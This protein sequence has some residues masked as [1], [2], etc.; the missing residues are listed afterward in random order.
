MNVAL[1]WKIPLIKTHVTKEDISAI[2]RVLERGMFLACGPEIE[3]F[4]R[5]IEEYLGN[6]VKV[7]TFNSGTS[8]LQILLEAHEIKGFKVIVP[9][10]TFIATANAVLLAGGTPIFAESE[11]ETFG[12]SYDSVKNLIDEKGVKAVMIMHYGGC[13]ARDTY[14]IK[15][16]CEDKKIL[17]LEDAAQSFSSNINGI[18]TGTFGESS[19]FSL[20]QNKILT[21]GEGGLLVTKNMKIYEKAKLLRSHGRV[22]E[23]VDYFNNT[24]D[25]DYIVPGYNA[26]MPTIN[27]AF[28]L[29]QLRNVPYVQRARNFLASRLSEG[30]KSLPIRL[31]IQPK[32]HLHV[33]QMYT[34]ILNDKKTRDDLQEHLTRKRIMTKVYFQPIH[35]KTLYKNHA[36]LPQTE[37]LA[38]KV[39]T[40]PLYPDLTKEEVDYMIGCIREYFER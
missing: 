31:P 1:D 26:R 30:L 20:C 22:E 17:F 24:K 6:G 16:L 13:P 34:M 15:K 35:L 36:Q 5:A 23:A 25:N 2:N 37:A 21:T 9:S 4:E 18:M 33:F 14:K 19:I 3:E 38:E 10:F 39:L 28:G 40:L 7:L 8:A 12:L 32:N 29:S 27:A 11:E